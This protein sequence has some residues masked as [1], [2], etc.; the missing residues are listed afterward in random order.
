MKLILGTVQLGLDYGITNSTG[1]PDESTVFRL[2][3]L[4]WKIILL[5]LIQP[6]DM[7]IVREY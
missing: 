1:K 3:K 5:I 7:E 6:E 4:L 2:S